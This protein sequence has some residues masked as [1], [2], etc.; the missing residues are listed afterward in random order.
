[1]NEMLKVCVGCYK[2]CVKEGC[3]FHYLQNGLS[4]EKVWAAMDCLAT[5]GSEETL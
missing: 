4:T 2:D 1:M 3:V 5:R